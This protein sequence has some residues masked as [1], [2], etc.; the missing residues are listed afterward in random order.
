MTII[1]YADKLIIIYFKKMKTKP[2]TKQK[3][4]VKKDIKN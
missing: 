1:K 4:S 3:E 2:D